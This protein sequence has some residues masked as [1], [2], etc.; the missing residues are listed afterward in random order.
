MRARA[1]AGLPAC[2]P[3]LSPAR[4]PARPPERLCACSPARAFADARVPLQP[5][6]L[7]VNIRQ[8][9]YI[10]KQLP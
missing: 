2:P 1:P 8:H 3:A 10:V 4:L 6:Y 7:Y 9:P 5:L